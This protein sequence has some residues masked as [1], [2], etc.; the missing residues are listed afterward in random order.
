[1]SRSLPKPNEVSSLLAGLTGRS[2]QFKP[3]KPHAFGKDFPEVI[4]LYRTDAGELGAAVACDIEFAA[5]AGA[6]L[7][8]IPADVVKECADD[9]EMTERIRE[10]AHEVLNVAASL[11][12]QPG[13]SHLVLSEVILNAETPE[14]IAEL[15][16]KPGQ[17]SDLEGAIEGYPG[18]RASILLP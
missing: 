12:N 11:F 16:A 10:N 4:A 18:G 1:V 15:I 13:F 9:G 7:T 14:T 17:R 8:M 3:A 2:A 5:S 6:A